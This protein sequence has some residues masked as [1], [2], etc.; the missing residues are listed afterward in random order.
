[1]R[2][3]GIAN[4]QELVRKAN[5]D[6]AWYWDAVNDDLGLEWFRKYDKVFDSSAGGLPW[7]RWFAGGKCNIIAS[8]IDKHAR[9][10]PEKIA[11]IF[12]SEH[13][14]KK[15]TYGQLDV[16]VSRLAAA[17]AAAGIKKGDVVSIYL[18]MVPEAFYAIFAC[19]KIGAVHATVFSGFGAQALHSRLVD[20]KA[21]MLVTADVAKRRGKDI[22]LKSQWSKAVEGTSVSKIV[23]VDGRASG[24]KNNNV[25]VSYSEFVKGSGAART[26]EVMDAEDPLFILYTSG[27]TGRPK[28]TLQ[29]HGGFM[30]VAGQQAKYLVDMRPDDVLFWNADIGWITGQVWVVYGSAMVGATALVYEEALDYP[31]PDAWCRLIQEHKASIFGAAP[32]AIRL[33]MKS[34]VSTAKH[35]LSS[36]RIL[37]CTGEPINREAW[38]WFFEQVG[39]K[40]CPIINVSGGTEVG[41]AILGAAPVMALKPCTV[42]CPIPGFDADVFDESGKPAS[43]GYLVIKKPWPSMSRGI[44]NDPSRFIETYWSKYENVW[45]HGDIVSVD[46]DGLW[47]MR[48]RADDVIK[49]SGHRIGTAEVEAAVASHPAVAEAIAVGK[50]DELRGEAIVVCAVVR[51]GHTKNDSLKAEIAARVEEA[52]GRFARPQEVRLVSELPKTRTGKLVRRLVKAKIA[53]EGMEGQDLSMVEN[54][55]ALDGI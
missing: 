1:M 15:V 23:T 39:Q 31:A 53:G 32:T 46:G 47:Y 19:G 50:P 30:L 40:R 6:M 21:K 29:V 22:D 5:N 34:N 28:G 24:D 3:H 42:G 45:Y 4:Y 18:P 10:N 11:Y 55:S 27:T 44:L 36:L 26:T 54:P 37:A 8:A 7:T 48:G 2:K 51:D 33:F 35:D 17:M 49:V 38:E 12:A 52:I 16:E 41:G 20:S 9:E 43:E 25:V 13:G 14:L